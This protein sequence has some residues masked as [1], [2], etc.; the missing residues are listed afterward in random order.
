MS[1]KLNVDAIAEAA[2]KSGDFP[3]LTNDRKLR[4]TEVLRAHKR[5]PLLEKRFSRF[6]TDLAVAPAF[7]KDVWRIQGPLAAY[8]F[9]FLMQTLLERELRQ[10]MARAGEMSLPLYPEDRRC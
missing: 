7:L 6:R 9:A 8:F 1:W 5:Q 2:W 4:V 3:L 10:A